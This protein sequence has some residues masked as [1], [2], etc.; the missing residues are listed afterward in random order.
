MSYSVTFDESYSNRYIVS[1][2]FEG[3]AIKREAVIDTACSTTLIPLHIAKMF[4]LRHGNRSTVI[5]G[6]GTYDA[7]LYTFDNVLFGDL[8]IE[9]LSAFAAEY[10]GYLQNRILIGMNVL[11]N[12]DIRLKRTK[13]GVLHFDYEPWWVVGNRKYPCGFFFAEGGTR[14]VYPNLLVE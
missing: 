1:L 11:L 10:E 4:G 12:M 6:G 2:V 7:V 8:S 13:N 5:V 14:A 9:K 3:E